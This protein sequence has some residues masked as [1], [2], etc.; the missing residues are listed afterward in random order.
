LLLTVATADKVINL[1][2]IF[3][4]LTNLVE[5]EEH[6]SFD[7]MLTIAGCLTRPAIA[8]FSLNKQAQQDTVK[9]HKEPAS[10]PEQVDLGKDPLALTAKKL[11]NGLLFKEAAKLTTANV[12]IA[13]DADE[14]QGQEAAKMSKPEPPKEASFP[15]LIPD[16]SPNDIWITDSGA[17]LSM[18]PHRHWIHNLIMSCTS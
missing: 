18:T 10:L 8:Q 2:A 13:E 5:T 7:I 3:H 12:T 1:L 9:M 4:A 17:M 14:E 15:P 6:E 11:T 16:L